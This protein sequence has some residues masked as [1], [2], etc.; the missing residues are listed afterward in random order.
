MKKIILSMIAAAG[1]LSSIAQTGSDGHADMTPVYNHSDSVLPRWVIDVNGLAGMMTQDITTANSVSGYTNG[2]NLNTGKLKFDNGTSF[3]FD[4]QLGYFFG[5]KNHWGIGAG[6]MYL[7]QKG[8]LK[9]DGYHVEY[10]A[11]DA[12]GRIYRQLV[13]GNDLKESITSTNMNIP[14]LLK[15]KARFSK[16]WGFTAD[17][18]ALINLQMKNMYKTSANFNYEAI[19]KPVVNGDGGVTYVYDNSPTYSPT[20][21]VIT[22][23]YYLAHNPNGSAADFINRYRSAGY[24]VGLG[25]PGNNTQGSV[26]YT[27]GSI[28]FMLQPSMSY[29][30]SDNFAINLGLYYMYQSFKN[31]NLPNYRLASTNGDYSSSLNNVTS[32]N[33]Q[34]YG[35][36]L[37][38]RVLFGK[39][40]DT[41]LDGVPDKRDKCPTVW[42]LPQFQGCPD[43]D[44][45]GIPDA[46]DDCPTVPGLAKF[47]G[48]PD[49]DGDGI[50]DRLDECPFAAGPAKLH[51]C[52]D[53]DGDG[54]ADKDDL[55]PDKAG[56]AQFRGCPDTDGDGVPDNDDQCPEVPGPASNHGCPLAPPP[57]DTVPIT[58]P[59]FFELNKTTVAVSSYPVLEV[60]IKKLKA[61]PSAMII[62]HGHAD[63]TGKAKP[64]QRLSEKRAT[65]VREQLIQLGA[66]PKKIKVI[67]HG[68]KQ[69]AAS[70][71]T[72]EGRAQNRRAVINL[73]LR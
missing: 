9:L 47:H 19:Y 4:A 22:T 16:H 34:S 53:R 32:S 36:N 21:E 70:N 31:A 3:G 57:M 40:K 25:I 64:N 48:C 60:A 5:R 51:G 58:T 6:F 44:K 33:V 20:S 41:D 66:D 63:A 54:I 35:I 17:G 8:D 73:D 69:P 72:P 61:D 23:Q 24:N 14:I 27:T 52:P 12:S 56:L 49:T 59:I 67:G 62:I 2:M 1:A 29:Y 43:T 45:D 68:S 30:I 42:G 39:L 7:S 13:T 28:G 50:I 38:V 26:S 18:G 46:E 10:Q 11:T 71:D 55:C 65:A 37:G 15:Y